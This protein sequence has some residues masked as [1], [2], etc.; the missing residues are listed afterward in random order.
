MKEMHGVVTKKGGLR[1]EN[2]ILENLSNSVKNYD[3]EGAENWAKK[4]VEEGVDPVK[5]MDALTAAIRE[6]GDLFEKEEL[7]LPDLVGA[8]ETMQRATPIL[9]EEIKRT[10]AKKVSAGTVVTG[11]VLGDIHSIGIGMVCTLLT[12]SGFIVHHMGVNIQPEKF[13]EAIKEHDADLLAMSALL[14]L[15]A[16]EQKKVIDM[17]K[18]EGLRDKVKIVVG[19]GAI[20]ADFANKIGADGYESTATGGVELAKELLSVS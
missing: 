4:A 7:W 19:G 3:R 20:T 12:A 16:T 18:E 15:T 13:V 1:M 6:I 10:G 2:E 8:A 17:L 9:E 14:T 5:A 11:S